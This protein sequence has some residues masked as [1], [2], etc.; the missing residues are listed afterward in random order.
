M[1]QAQCP[2]CKR[3]YYGWSLIEGSRKECPECHVPLEVITD[4]IHVDTGNDGTDDSIN[5]SRY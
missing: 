4:D 3:I 2:E 1:L 5:D